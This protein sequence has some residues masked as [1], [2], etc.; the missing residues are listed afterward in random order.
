M[1][2]HWRSRSYI[3]S[4][5]RMMLPAE[6]RW[7]KV[8]SVRLVGPGGHWGLQ[9]EQFQCTGEV[10]SRLQCTEEEKE[11]EIVTNETLSKDLARR[12]RP[13]TRKGQK[14]K[15]KFLNFYKCERLE[16]IYRK[17]CDQRRGKG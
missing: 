7:G 15:G 17:T 8:N 11:K 2:A 10:Q 4:L 6:I 1:E 16:H 5:K 13:I 14:V 3:R 12:N 9:K